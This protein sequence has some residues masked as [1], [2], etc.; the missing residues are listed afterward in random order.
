MG[1]L[2]IAGGSLAGLR[3][4]HAARASGW[5]DD[6]VVVGDE[7]HMPYTRP[8]LSKGVLTTDW[9][10]VSDHHFPVDCEATWMLGETA[11][12]LDP[13]SRRLRLGSG[14]QLAY[15]RLIVA[16]G[17]RPRAWAGE[18]SDLAGLHTIRRVEDAVALREA[19]TRR[20]RLAV[21]GAGFIGCEVAASARALGLDVALFDVAPTPMPAL[22]PLLGER[23]AALHRD[24]GVS[25]HLGVGVAALRGDGERRIAAIEL[26]D[27]SIHEAD[28]AVIALGVVPAT[29]WL[30]GS[31]IEARMGVP[32]D[33]T[34][35]VIGAPDVLAAGDVACWP[36]PLADGESIRV[37]H[38]TNAAEHGIHAG[39]NAVLDATERRP[40]TGIPSFWSDQYETK[41][42][43][44]G[45]THLAT[46]YEVV[47]ES[48][49]GS[50]LVAIALRD[51]VLVGVVGFNAARRL[52][53]YRRRVG[54][55][56]DVDA[57]RAGVAGDAS[58][59]G[60]PMRLAA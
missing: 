40:Y 47:E 28:L 3:T 4:A 46:A 48:E 10:G 8:P 29:E 59:L 50:R 53:A 51:Q 26:A 20:P 45:L 41:I 9:L 33:E 42:Q 52:P 49:D 27:G 56:V 24:R 19:L 2:V 43:S 35:T 12:G 22:G 5:D 14:N 17:A 6:V 18:G 23:C 58:A 21:V 37:E 13:A 30:E 25:L 32:C 7:P 55:R 1:A 38:W 15:D 16:T 34:L 11:T 44:V 31:G 39:R 57:L 54:S 60:V 36:H